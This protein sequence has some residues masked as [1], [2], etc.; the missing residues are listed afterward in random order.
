M[1]AP[2]P[3]AQLAAELRA[4]SGRERRFVLSAL[5]PDERVRLKTALADRPDAAAIAAGGDQGVGIFSPWLSERLRDAASDGVG[6]ADG[7]QM[8]AAARQRLRTAAQDVLAAGSADASPAPRSASLL[9][10]L[11]LLLAP[12]RRGA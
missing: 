6:G 4:L 9:D 5:S 1:S 10:S 7:W 3:L 11:I 8:T 2:E 12:R